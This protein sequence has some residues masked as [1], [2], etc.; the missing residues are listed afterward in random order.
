[1]SYNPDTGEAGAISRAGSLPK[2][3]REIGLVG[4]GIGDHGGEAILDWSDQ[5]KRLQMTR[6][7]ENR[8]SNPLKKRFGTLAETDPYLLVVV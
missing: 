6:V 7:E 5:A 4:C 1:M 2:T 8:F 3:V